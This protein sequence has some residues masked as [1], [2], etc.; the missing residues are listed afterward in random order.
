MPASSIQVVGYIADNSAR[1]ANSTLKRHVCG[2]R[3]IH[4]LC[5]FPSPVDNDEVNLALRRACRA[6]LSR[7]KQA[8]GLT[9]KLRDEVLMMAGDDL[10]ALR[11]RAMITVAYDTLC[12]RGELVALCAEDIEVKESGRVTILVRRAKNDPYGTGRIAWLSSRSLP[13]LR[14]WLEAANIQ[15]GPMFRPIY[16]GCVIARPLN[17]FT[18]ARVIKGMASKAG[19]DDQTIKRLSGHSMRVGAA[20]DL[21]TNGAGILTIMRAGGWKSMNIVA[22]YVE[23]AD[24]KIWD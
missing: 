21:M 23:H 22:R 4:K 5:G 8:L 1:F 9:Q 2:I 18:V 20:Q 17:A 24:I 7:P 19:L 3:R 6:K 11:D 14:E 12:R 15:E 10:V 16:K 13:I